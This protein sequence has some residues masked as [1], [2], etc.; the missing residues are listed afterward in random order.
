MPSFQ[1]FSLT[2]EL[3]R[4]ALAILVAIAALR[5]ASATID[6][7]EIGQADSLQPQHL[8]QLADI[9][10]AAAL[11]AAPFLAVVMRRLAPP[12]KGETERDCCFCD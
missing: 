6:L 5:I 4:T 12:S 8:I 3:D 9:A 1:R 10:A 7:A 11:A 2:A